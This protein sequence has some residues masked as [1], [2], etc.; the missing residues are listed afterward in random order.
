MAKK[1][2]DRA[3]AACGLSYSPNRLRCPNCGEENDQIRDGIP[4]EALR[5]T[6]RVRLW[7][8]VWLAAGMLLMPP[9]F[10]LHA[11]IPASDPNTRTV[12]WTPFF[13][14]VQGKDLWHPAEIPCMA[15]LLLALFNCSKGWAEGLTGVRGMV[16]VKLNPA[17]G[18]VEFRFWLLLVASVALALATLFGIFMV[19]RFVSEI[20]L[21]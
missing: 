8:L 2:K 6:T 21:P 14:V 11:Q 4:V 7:G 19:L 18:W 15:L 3:C 12:L 20:L 10:L 17:H 5:P 1:R 16:L 13:R 9:V